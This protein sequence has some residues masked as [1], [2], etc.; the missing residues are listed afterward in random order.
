MITV[1]FIITKETKK[2]GLILTYKCLKKNCKKME[3]IL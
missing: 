1:M 3:F 2:M